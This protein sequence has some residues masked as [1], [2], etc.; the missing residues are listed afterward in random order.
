MS[1]FGSF[2]RSAVN[3]VGRDTGRAISN[4]V[5][6]NAHSTPVRQVE[7]LSYRRLSAEESPLDTNYV[8]II[9]YVPIKWFWA[10]FI[11]FLLPIVGGLIIFF[12]GV[13][14]INKKHMQAHIIEAHEVYQRDRRFSTG[15]KLLGQKN[16][17]TEVKVDISPRRRRINITKCTGY[18]IIGAGT[19]AFYIYLARR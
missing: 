12:R 5:L 9:E 13:I 7:Q 17:Y 19:I 4:Q 8:E 10:A 3:Q 6:G 2:V 14:N 15:R 1:L 11:S 18:I 16:I